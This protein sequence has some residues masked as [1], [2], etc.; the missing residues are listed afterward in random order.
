MNVCIRQFGSMIWRVMLLRVTLNVTGYLF[1]VRFVAGIVGDL[2]GGL[3]RK[4]GEN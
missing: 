2:P 3:D 4:T 1:Q